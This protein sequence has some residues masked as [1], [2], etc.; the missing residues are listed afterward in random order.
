MYVSQ[1]WLYVGSRAGYQGSQRCLI[2][3]VPWLSFLNYPRVC[4]FLFYLFFNQYL[5]MMHCNSS[6]RDGDD[7]IYNSVPLPSG[8]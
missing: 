1:M 7:N 2:W 3:G 6:L 4:H 8:C 5:G